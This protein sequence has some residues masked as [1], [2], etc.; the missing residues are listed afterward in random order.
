MFFWKRCLITKKKL[1]INNFSIFVT[2]L[3]IF[4]VFNS[5]L[6]VFKVNVSLVYWLLCSL[7]VFYLFF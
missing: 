2:S 5:S 6:D 7:M 1:F 3:M 4:T